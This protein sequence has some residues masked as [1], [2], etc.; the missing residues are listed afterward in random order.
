MAATTM[1]PA[2]PHCPLCRD[3][4]GVLVARAER[5]RV[6][7]VED[8]DFPAFYRV[9]WSAHVAELSELP[10]A[11]RHE[12]M[13]VVCA[14]EQVL[15]A[16]LQPTKINLASLGNMVPHLHWHVI[17]RF[18]WDSRFPQAIWAPAERAVEPPASTRLAVPLGRLDAAVVG[19]VGSL[20]N[21]LP[22]RQSPAGAAR[23]TA[24]P[25]RSV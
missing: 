6:V 2:D 13:D 21:S 7:R 5:W 18:D 25:D 17:A 10:P 15:R 11:Q 23:S 22:K 3:D 9:I 8:A 20:R 12:L 4:G 19:A 16:Q 24:R 1:A 14:V